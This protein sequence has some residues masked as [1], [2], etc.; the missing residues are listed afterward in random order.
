MATIT[1]HYKTAMDTVFNEAVYK[2]EGYGWMSSAMKRVS[3]TQPLGHTYGMTGTLPGW[4]ETKG[5]IT[6]RG[7]NS[8]TLSIAP[9]PF[10]SG[11]S[12]HKWDIEYDQFNI[13][14]AQIAELG[15]SYQNL[16]SL[17]AT[18]VLLNGTGT[19]ALGFDGLPLFS[20][21]HV[22]GPNS[23]TQS[24]N[25][26]IDISDLGAVTVANTGTVPSPEE[27]R[28]VL[29]RA[30]R[31]MLSFKDSEGN[32][33]PQEGTASFAVIAP[34]ELMEAFS[35][36]LDLI[37]PQGLIASTNPLARAGMPMTFQVYGSLRLDAAPTVFYMLRTDTESKPLAMQ[38]LEGLQTH[39]F[40]PYTSSNRT[41]S[42]EYLATWSGNA[43]PWDWTKAARFT[44]AR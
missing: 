1:Y 15:T 17:L 32:Q 13:L 30:G 11:L 24:N 18:N 10:H 43:A 28:K 3:A 4:Q 26:T 19:G 20:A 27:A 36:G 21:S 34:M 38:E 12:F 41:N 39:V 42:Y 33:Q 5:P 40:E 44:L 37:Q 25:L 6:T 2:G 16:Q 31:L 7:L 35:E 9:K 8:Y 22:W 29:R 23:G 14:N